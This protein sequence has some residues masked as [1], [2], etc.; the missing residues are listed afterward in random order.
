MRFATAMVSFHSNRNPKTKIFFINPGEGATK[1][2]KNIFRVKQDD[3]VDKG[4]TT[5]ADNLISTLGTN[6][7]RPRSQ[8]G[9]GQRL[10]QDCG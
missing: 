6:L 1:T 3:L 8:E 9:K 4:I 7:V 5:K 10:Q 2:R